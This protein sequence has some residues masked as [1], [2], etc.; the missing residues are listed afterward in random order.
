M[1]RLAANTYIIIV[2]GSANTKTTHIMTAR[3]APKDS[4]VTASPHNNRRTT[5]VWTK[6]GRL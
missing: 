4:P 5:T 6:D 1:A 3:D 2:T